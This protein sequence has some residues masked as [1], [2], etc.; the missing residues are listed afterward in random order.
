MFSKMISFHRKVAI[1]FL[2]A[3]SVQT[4]P[5]GSDKSAEVDG[6]DKPQIQDVRC[7]THQGDNLAFYCQASCDYEDE[8]HVNETRCGPDLER[9]TKQ[10]C[11]CVPDPICGRACKEKK[12]LAMMNNK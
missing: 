4:L 1:L 7:Y 6:I 11:Y 3:G 10:F 8:I 9:Q 12:K 5:T 2:A